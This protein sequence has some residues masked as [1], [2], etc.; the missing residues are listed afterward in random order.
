MPM[1]PET[2]SYLHSLVDLH[3]QISQGK[4]DDQ[5][6]DDIRDGM[7]VPCRKMSENDTDITSMVSVLLYLLDGQ[8]KEP[9]PRTAT[10]DE[11]WKLLV[12]FVSDSKPEYLE[13]AAQLLVLSVQEAKDPN[14]DS[15]EHL[16]KAMREH[17]KFVTK[18]PERA[19]AFLVRAGILT[20]S[21]KLSKNYGGE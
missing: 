16:L 7:D 10:K 1:N 9:T 5:E 21:G 11:A 20:P 4:G 15:R 12:K 2:K 8:D 6:A 17:R 3:D 13:E 18:T 14:T 19:R